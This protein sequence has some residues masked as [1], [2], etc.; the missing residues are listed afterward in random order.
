MKLEIGDKIETHPKVWVQIK[1]I[2][3]TTAVVYQLDNNKRKIK[4]FRKEGYLMGIFTHT[5][6]EILAL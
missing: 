4:L 5:E 3:A 6:S 2:G 1:S